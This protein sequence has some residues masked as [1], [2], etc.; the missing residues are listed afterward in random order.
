NVDSVRDLADAVV[1]VLTPGIDVVKTALRDPVLD[2]GAPAVAGPDVPTVR[3]A[4][5][6]YDVSNTGTIALDLVPD[7]PVDD[8]CSPLVPATPL[9]DDNGNG[10][11]DP[12]EVW[13]YTCSTTLD[14]DD[15]NT[16]PVTGDESG[17]VTNTVTATG[18]P[19]LGNTRFPD[20]A[21]SASDKAQVL[22]I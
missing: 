15:A 9:G 11:L 22:V 16:P 21:V 6:T 5:Y 1:N 10:L 3:P 2:P 7:P 18:V 20:L 14:R 8:I 17:L 19:V 12:D 13:H 4:E